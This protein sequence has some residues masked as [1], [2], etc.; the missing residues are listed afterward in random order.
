MGRHVMDL[1]GFLV[2]AHPQVFLAEQIHR[3]NITAFMFYLHPKLYEAV[4]IQ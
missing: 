4:I 2:E 3:C 1:A